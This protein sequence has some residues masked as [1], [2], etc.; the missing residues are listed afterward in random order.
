MLDLSNFASKHTGPARTV[1]A[2]IVRKNLGKP[3][4]GNPYLNQPRPGPRI[5]NGVQVDG[6]FLS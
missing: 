5:V 3:V 1:G 4:P 6:K 2:E